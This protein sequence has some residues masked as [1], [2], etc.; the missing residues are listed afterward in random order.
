MKKVLLGMSVGVALL[1]AASCAEDKQGVIPVGEGDMVVAHTDN[2]LT[3]DDKVTITTK[4]VGATTAKVSLIKNREE[5]VLE[6]AAPVVNNLCTVTLNVADLGLAEKGDVATVWVNAAGFHDTRTLTVVEPEWNWTA[7]KGSPYSTV[8]KSTVANKVTFTLDA[9]W[10]TNLDSLKLTVSGKT[11]DLVS[12]QRLSNGKI[13][14]QVG[15]FTANEAFA[16]GDGDKK[17]ITINATYKVNDK[18]ATNKYEFACNIT[19]DTYTKSAAYTFTDANEVSDADS[20]NWDVTDR[21]RTFYG[22][23]DGKEYAGIRAATTGDGAKQPVLYLC[24]SNPCH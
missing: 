2:V 4:I 9:P 11:S 1:L 21:A 13:Q 14:I 20:T 8:E 15:T 12:K 24:L 16:G 17:N 10:L 22:L 5:T 18:E 6:A 23:Y 7:T 19:Q 3:I